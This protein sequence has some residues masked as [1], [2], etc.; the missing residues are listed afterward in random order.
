MK[1]TNRRQ[2]GSSSAD[3]ARQ[4]R[5]SYWSGNHDAAA[6]RGRR[7]ALRSRSS[8]GYS[9]RSGTRLVSASGEATGAR[10]SLK[11]KGK[12]KQTFKKRESTP[13]PPP[14]CGHRCCPRRTSPLPSRTRSPGAHNTTWSGFECDRAASRSS[15]GS[16]RGKS[17]GRKGVPRL[18]RL[19]GRLPR[20]HP[21]SMKSGVSRRMSRQATTPSSFFSGA[22]SER[23]RTR[24][25]SASGQRLRHR[26]LHRR[27][28]R[29][30]RVLSQGRCG[31]A[32]G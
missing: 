10:Y 29:P 15:Q 25:W 32:G 20:C 22:G 23:H 26:Q 9:S 8:S 28:L 27:K 21:N 16:L 1:G 2:H 12:P 17:A 4:G 3:Q 13:A 18:Q 6:G 24:G 11:A 14:R 19:P 5:C 7:L 30:P 31:P